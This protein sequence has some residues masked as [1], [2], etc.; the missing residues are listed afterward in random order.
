MNHY[1]SFFAGILVMIIYMLVSILYY[2]RV[3][4]TTLLCVDCFGSMDMYVD[5][6]KETWTGI[7]LIV[8]LLIVI[9]IVKWKWDN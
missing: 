3:L 5:R 6:I 8:P 2:E 4:E 7:L 9:R 1:D